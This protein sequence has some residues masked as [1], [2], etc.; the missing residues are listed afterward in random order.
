MNSNKD[1][2]FIILSS[3]GYSLPI[4]SNLNLII[5]KNTKPNNLKIADLQ[6]GLIL[7]YIGT[8]IIGEGTGFGFPIVIYKG[9]SYFSKSAQVFIKK[10]SASTI[11]KKEFNMNSI[12]RNK[13]KNLKLENKKVRSI[14][15]YLSYLYQKHKK[16]RFL[17][18]KKF[19]IDIGI[20]SIYEKTKS[21][22]TIPVTYIITGK[23]IT[24]E[25][26]LH[27]IE[28]L[29]P[30]KIFVLNEQSANFFK[31]Y[32]DSNKLTLK[33]NEFGAWDYVDAKWAILTDLNERLGYKL[34]RINNTILCR[35][36]ETLKN[37][38]DWAGLDYQIKPNT[39]RFKYKIELLEKN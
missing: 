10:N 26:D 30:Q 38:L 13:Y 36:R 15:R 33:N 6:K 29:H 32:I 7:E 16:L 18:L 21:I 8:E 9:E 1:K 27:K 25:V 37:R 17:T 14:I 5:Y 39:K 3:Q 28:R 2:N 24:I 4:T 35:G 31:K 12:A 20:K 34:W 22:G 11:I 23:K 19:F